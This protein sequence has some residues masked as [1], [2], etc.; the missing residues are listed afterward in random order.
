MT[1]REWGL[2]FRFYNNLFPSSPSLLY[3]LSTLTLI[4]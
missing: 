1:L 4:Y 3:L 2:P